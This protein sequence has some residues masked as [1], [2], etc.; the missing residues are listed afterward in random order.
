M[1]LMGHSILKPPA[2]R[3]YI[4]WMIRRDMP[5]VLAIERGAFEFPWSEQDFI[6]VLRQRNAIGLV[7]DVDD[8]VAGYVIYELHKTRLHLVNLAV[9]RQFARWGVGRAMIT[10]LQG[11]L[12]R[13]RRRRIITEVRER[14]LP[15][16]LFFRSLGFRAVTTLRR[17]YEDSDEDA[18]VFVHELAAAGNGEEVRN[19]K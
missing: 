3:P 10:K 8:A 15:A 13:A 11:K 17:Y 4:R 7:A 1:T 12:S 2:V 9:A 18:Y 5:E 6:D 14:N 16:Q 19:A